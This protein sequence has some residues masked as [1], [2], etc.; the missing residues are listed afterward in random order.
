LH[1][2]AIP[3]SAN[4]ALNGVG[5]GSINSDNRTNV[6]WQLGAGTAYAFT[7][8]ISLDVGYRYMDMGKAQTGDTF[9]A[10]NGATVGGVRSTADLHG[11]ELQAGLRFAF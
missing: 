6:A 3:G 8:S 7:P 4:L 11:S 2:R 9:T 1:C 10:V 5:I